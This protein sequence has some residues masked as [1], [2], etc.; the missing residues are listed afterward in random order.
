M[1]GSSVLEILESVSGEKL[2]IVHR[3][4]VSY[5]RLSI[6]PVNVLW[7]YHGKVERLQRRLFSTMEHRLLLQ[8]III[9]TEVLLPTLD[10]YNSRPKSSTLWLP[11][12]VRRYR[13]RNKSKSLSIAVLSPWI[14]SSVLLIRTY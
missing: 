8:D 7:G 3:H 5:V 2:E 4:R 14:N 13:N 1:I 9:G 6:V 10:R 12:P 11:T